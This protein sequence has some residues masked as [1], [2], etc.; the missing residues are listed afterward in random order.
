MESRKS[1]KR[2]KFVDIQYI[3]YGSL[4]VFIITI[5]ITFWAV[6]DGN[7][8]TRVPSIE[9]VSIEEAERTIKI[10][11]LEVGEIRNEYNSIVED[12]NI[13]E[14]Y[15]K[16]NMKVKKKSK[17]NLVVSLGGK[18][19]IV[20]KVV[21]EKLDYAKKKLEEAGLRVQLIEEE[22][23]KVEEGYIIKQD[24]NAET[25]VKEG[26]IITITVSKGVKEEEL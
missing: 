23:R 5:L 2:S 10:Y 22:N 17:V 6:K 1:R 18:D 7:T 8:Y 26:S 25:I 11:D 3:I 14:Q 19:V 15:P 16:E 13:I 9:G 4:I 12:G 20:P 21:G 24:I